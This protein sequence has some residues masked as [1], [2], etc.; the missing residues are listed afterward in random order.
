M[1]F[2]LTIFTTV[3][4]GDMSAVTVGE[5]I[6]VAL[7]MFVGTV[8]HSI[9][10]GEVINLVSEVDKET[11]WKQTRRDLAE[12]FG[13][14]TNLEQ[15]TVDELLNFVGHIKSNGGSYDRNEM[16]KFLTGMALPRKLLGD[17]P[18]QL[19]DK[20]LLQNKFVSICASATADKCVPPRFA[21]ILSTMLTSQSFNDG[22]IVFH[23]RDHAFN[24]YFVLKGLF[25]YVD[26]LPRVN[27]D[28]MEGEEQVH[29]ER[30]E[31]FK[32]NHKDEGCEQVA[33]SRSDMVVFDPRDADRV[34]SSVAGIVNAAGMHRLK[35]HCSSRL[36]QHSSA[37][38]A[39]PRN[40]SKSSGG[41]CSDGPTGS[42]RKPWVRLDLGSS[43]TV[44]GIRMT[45]H[46]TKPEWVKTFKVWASTLGA[47]CSWKKVKDESDNDLFYRDSEGTVFEQLFL[48]VKARFI[49][50]EAQDWER[51]CSMR[52]A[53]IVLMPRMYPY[54]TFGHKNFF[55]EEVLQNN[56]RVA[57]VRCERKG[58]LLLLHKSYLRDASQ[59]L[60]LLNEFPEYD[61][62][63]KR[64][65][66]NRES[67]R[68]RLHRNMSREPG[69]AEDLARTVLARFFGPR[70]QTKPKQTLHH[71]PGMTASD[72]LVSADAVARKKS[73]LHLASTQEPARMVN[74]SVDSMLI[75]LMEDM[76]REV[77]EV[78][79]ELRE[80]KATLA[81]QRQGPH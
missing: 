8:V 13:K 49:H 67:H 56:L 58:D 71:K 59:G 4:F 64:E 54:Q 72:L 9:V 41:P 6:T 40:N 74:E 36:G 46:P 21:L 25:A 69:N 81:A 29:E 26:E 61:P 39:N 18:A 3:G 33:N 45:G 11:V 78:R 20:Q 47:A 80:V 79:E 53:M 17:I 42:D 48:P 38:T 62:P 31:R 63:L 66:V 34:Y 37:W 30:D 23:R 57:S 60:A 16:T 68:R 75:S 55:G 76:R 15:S 32:G 73:S 24:M 51:R 35:W 19:F 1:Y 22:D 27:I 7:V 12:A 52:V 65:C 14:H 70:A 5:I 43:L 77:R 2:V 50:I 10:I 44:C 28:G